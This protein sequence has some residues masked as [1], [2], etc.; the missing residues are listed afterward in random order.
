MPKAKTSRGVVDEILQ[1]VRNKTPGFPCWFD[2]LPDEY[3]QQF[4]DARRQFD[5]AVHQAS[6]YARAIIAV[7]KRH[8]LTPPS[9]QWVTRWLR[10]K[11]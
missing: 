10:R 4:L 6:A 11:E 7:A 5:P 9:E 3:R 8:G 2:K 1:T